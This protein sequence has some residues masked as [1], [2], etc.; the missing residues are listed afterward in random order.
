M[1]AFEGAA[2]DHLLPCTA[3]DRETCQIVTKLMTW[4][5]LLRGSPFEI[6]EYP[7]E[8]NQLCLTYVILASLTPGKF[9]HWNAPMQSETLAWLL[10]THRCIG[11]VNIPHSIDD[12]TRQSLLRAVWQNKFVK[13]LRLSS[14]RLPA[15]GSICAALP[16]LTNIRTLHFSTTDTTLDCF[17]APLSVLLQAS[18]SLK[19]LRLTGRFTD[20]EMINTL[21]GALLRKPSLEELDFAVLS[22]HGE[23]YPQALKQ[24]LS[25]TTALKALAVTMTRSVMKVLLEGVLENRSIEKLSL[26]GSLAN[27]ECMAMVS[28]LMREH[29]AIRTLSIC[30]MCLHSRGPQLDYNSWVLPLVQNEIL[31]EV[32][33]PS[34]ILQLAMWSVFFKA[35][36]KKDNMK[37]VRI[38]TLPE[39][40]HAFCA[41]LKY[42]G[43]EEKVS[44]STSDFMGY[45]GVLE[46]K[47]FSHA[48][49]DESGKSHLVL[50]ALLHLPNCQHL[51]HVNILINDHYMRL[52]L[53]LAEFLGSTMT[54]EGLIVHVRGVGEVPAEVATPWWNVVVQSLS[55][56]T[57]LKEFGFS[58]H[59]MSVQDARDLADSV[60]ENRGIRRLS[61]I[62]GDKETFS[63]FIGRLS[64]CI[65]ENYSLTMVD[66]RLCVHC[67]PVDGWYTVKET[68]L[69]NSGLVA[70]AARIK[71]ASHLD[72]YVTGALERVV[73]HPALLDE[74]AKSAKLD[75]EELT[76]LVR[77]RLRSTQSMD[78]FMQVV[79]VVKE[80]VVCHPADDGR[81]Q[82]D[83]LNE[84]C[85]SFVR[86]YLKTDEVKHG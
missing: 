47:A 30:S 28:R 75:H 53:A 32:E 62:A 65:Q 12:N 31:E 34:Y 54:L 45:S 43:S 1:A 24:Y 23:A 37:M 2:D 40:L 58:M 64:E 72:R 15:V 56:N 61:L 49:L 84:Y 67:D 9:R 69:R 11:S 10:E 46:C 63:T 6:Q 38:H 77:D 83:D 29:P 71:Q 50:A 86:R 41:V 35:L 18:S 21:F 85:W 81:T 79:G 80:R 59:G 74:V 55:R 60:I 13:T 17:V 27:G 4:N 82:L 44:L 48:M 7:E 16:C 33:L 68:V 36:A 25:S 3:S 52:S 73:Q 5:K 14:V 66:E 39:D 22:D 76:L 70:R 26:E 20:G 42:S 78:G 51:K 57:S 19:C 8:S